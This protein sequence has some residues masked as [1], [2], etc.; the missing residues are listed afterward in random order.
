MAIEWDEKHVRSMKTS[1]IVGCL[2]DPQH[3]FLRDIIAGANMYDTEKSFRDA[4]Q[5]HAKLVMPL[6]LAEIDRR[7]P[8]PAE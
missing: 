8:V 1:A 7:I 3:T 4:L 5:E 2:M 6:L